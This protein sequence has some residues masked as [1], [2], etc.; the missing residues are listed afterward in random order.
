[1]RDLIPHSA[2]NA[3]GQSRVSG[4][5]AT[6]AIKSMNTVKSESR[7]VREFDDDRAVVAAEDLRQ[8]VGFFQART[9]GAGDEEIIEP[10]ADVP[11]ARGAENAPPSVVSPTLLEFPE[12]VQEA[13]VHEGTEALTLLDGEAVVADVGLGIGEVQF[14][15][16]DVEVAA[17]DHRLFLFQLLEVGEEIPV[18]LLPVGQAG[19]IALG[20]GHIDIDEEEALGLG[21]EHA[22]FLVVL[23]DTQ[24]RG[25]GKRAVFD[26]DGSAGVAA[27]LGAVPIGGVGRAKHSFV[28]QYQALSYSLGCLSESRGQANCFNFPAPPIATP[29]LRRRNSALFS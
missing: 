20:I 8:D 3:S 11:G 28:S 7:F 5:A 24:V 26:E 15:V 23:D 27:L 18:P 1:M 6:G 25:N 13:G 12:R 29:A 17:E 2:L 21:G 4:M 9:Q 10:P 19:Q 22:A 14:G 16:R